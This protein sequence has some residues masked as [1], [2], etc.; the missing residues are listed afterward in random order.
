MA[1]STRARLSLAA[2]ALAA[3]AATF[4]L[5]RDTSTPET[6]VPSSAGGVVLPLTRRGLRQGSPVHDDANAVFDPTFPRAE[7]KGIGEKYKNAAQFLSGVGLNPDS[8]VNVADTYGPGASVPFDIATNGTIAPAPLP[9]ATSAPSTGQAAFEADIVNDLAGRAVLPVHNNVGTVPLRDQVSG[10]EDLLYYGPID[11]GT[12]AQTLTVDVDTGSSDLW[13]PSACRRCKGRQFDARRSSTFRSSNDRFSVTYGSGRVSGTLVRDVV[14]F[15]D[16]SVSS[17]AFGAVSDES[18]DFSENPN[19]GLI[20]MA[21][22]TI[23]ESHAP[24]FFENLIN[25]HAVRSPLFGIHLERGR[26][27]G[28]EMCLG[29]IDSN[30][31]LGPITWIPVESQTYWSVSLDAVTAG[32]NTV[33]ANCVAAIDTGTTLIY[34]P[35]RLTAAF[36]RAIGG[37]PA[38]QYGDGFWT[39]PCAANLN[40]NFVFGGHGFSLDPRD[41]NLGHT[42][43]R[44][45]DCIGAVLSLHSG[46][47]FPDNLAIIGDAFLKS[48]YSVYDYSDGARVGLAADVNQQ[49]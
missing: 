46:Q 11:I 27:V 49:A 16:L 9:T 30:K 43:S 13:L 35:E 47:G 36:Y 15:G 7:L 5:G 1:S 26:V 39:Y 45:S 23:A 17:Q 6:V 19:D 14:S 41:F 22:G 2:L 33:R 38:S 42:S 12:P 20:G 25:R 29:C 21:F 28:S 18:G 31:M 37:R 34:L 4:P 40:I 3:A 24:T 10:T 48:W 32:G 44:S 8:A